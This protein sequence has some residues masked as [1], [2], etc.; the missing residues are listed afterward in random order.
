MRWAAFEAPLGEKI[1]AC[2]G[3]LVGIAK[4]HYTDEKVI[5]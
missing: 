2:S 3:I 5:L 1:S 4:R